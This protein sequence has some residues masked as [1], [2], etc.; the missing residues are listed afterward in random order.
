M[1]CQT[2]WCG[3]NTGI[4]E[5][6]ILK[7]RP[8]CEDN[9]RTEHRGQHSKRGNCKSKGQRPGGRATLVVRA[10]QEEG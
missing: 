9:G 5:K 2:D 3:H 6:V 1:M 8:E 4:C 10:D 7:L